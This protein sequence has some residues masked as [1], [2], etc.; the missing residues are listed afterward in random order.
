MFTSQSSKALHSDPYAGWYF[1]GVFPCD[2][3]PNK[4]TFFHRVLLPTLIRLINQEHIGW[5]TTL[6]GMVI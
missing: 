5:H 3:L 2:R 4:L 6:I 1:D